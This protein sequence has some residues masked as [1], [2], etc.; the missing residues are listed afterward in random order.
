M[1]SHI[2]HF[3]FHEDAI[4]MITKPFLFTTKKRLRQ[5]QPSERRGGN[6]TRDL[7]VKEGFFA[8]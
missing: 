1:Q 2:S 3:I 6:K 4:F 5:K 7:I 8:P